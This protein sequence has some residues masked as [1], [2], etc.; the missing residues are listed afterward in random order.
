MGKAEPFVVVK[1]GGRAS[2]KESAE[3]DS[4][5]IRVSRPP[6]SVYTHHEYSSE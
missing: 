6:T 2:G 5:V 1:A 3:T 4:A